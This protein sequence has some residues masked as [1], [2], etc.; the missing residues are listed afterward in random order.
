MKVNVSQLEITRRENLVSL[1]PV[2]N[3]MLDK[4]EETG[5]SH[6][7]HPL[8]LCLSIAETKH[9]IQNLRGEGEFAPYMNDGIHLVRFHMRGMDEIEL[10][11][12]RFERWYFTMPGEWLADRLEEAIEQ[13]PET[14][15]MYD[16]D[17]FAR[18]R[19]QYRAIVKWDYADGVHTKILED[20]QDERAPGLQRALDGLWRIASNESDGIASW[21]HLRFDARPKENEPA[22]YYFYITVGAEQKCSM[23]GG[24]IA[25]RDWDYS[26]DNRVALDT[27]RYSTHT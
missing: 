27:W 3:E 12:D 15:T 10:S 17:T 22:S 23:N 5:K 6:Y 25:H 14:K 18:L 13:Q 7:A 24:I 16:S 4:A 2:S 8:W 20:L 11:G 21:I 9:A 19:W 1:H 26:G